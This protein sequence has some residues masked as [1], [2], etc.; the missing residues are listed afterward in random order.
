MF[1]FS[2]AKNLF[3]QP[4]KGRLGFVTPVGIATDKTAARFF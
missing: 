4:V 3:Q 2:V 1:L